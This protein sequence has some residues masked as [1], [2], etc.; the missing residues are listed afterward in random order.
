MSKTSG[1]ILARAVDLNF[2]E[3]YYTVNTEE[4]FLS[5]ATMIKI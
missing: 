4:V 5:K 1:K 2:H 3:V